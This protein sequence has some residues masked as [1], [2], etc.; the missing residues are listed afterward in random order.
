MLGRRLNFLSGFWFTM[1]SSL[2]RSVRQLFA[3][4]YLLYYLLP[5]CT[6]DVISFIEIV[7]NFN[8]FYTKCKMKKIKKCDIKCQKAD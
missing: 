1:F 4:D 7:A 2:D 8:L 6:C 3:A 5:L